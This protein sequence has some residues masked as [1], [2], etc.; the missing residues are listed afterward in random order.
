[1][2]A[3]VSFVCMLSSLENDH[4]SE[5]SDQA[6]SMLRTCILCFTYSFH[7]EVWRPPRRPGVYTETG[8]AAPSFLLLLSLAPGCEPVKEEEWR[9]DFPTGTP[10]CALGTHCSSDGIRLG[11]RIPSALTSILSQ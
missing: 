1:M 2:W 6:T 8:R 11:P 9:S 5:A 4:G 7:W 10:T 3:I